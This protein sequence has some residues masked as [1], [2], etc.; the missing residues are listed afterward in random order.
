M[1]HFL[2]RLNEKISLYLGEWTEAPLLYDITWR[3]FL[4]TASLLVLL[5]A[6]ERTLRALMNRRLRKEEQRDVPR[7]WLQVF[8]SSTGK[9]LSLIIWVYGIYIVFRPVLVRFELEDGTNPIY[10]AVRLMA[11]VGGTIALFWFGMRFLKLVDHFYLRWAS[12]QSGVLKSLAASLSQSSPAPL[13][14]LMFLLLFRI[15][16]SFFHLPDLP[17]SFHAF[18]TNV[19]GVVLIASISWLL[20]EGARV[21]ELFLLSF[22]RVDVA[23]NRQARR[24]HTQLRFLRHFIVILVFI[25][26]LASILMLFDQV[27]QLGASLLASAGVLGIVVGLAA[28]RSIANLLVGLQIA[29]TQPITLDDV[30]I[31]EGEWG[32]IEEITAT[33]V[34]VRIWDRRCLIVPL[35]YFTETPFQNWTRTS[36]QILGTIFLYVDYT[37]N[38]E[39]IR[40]KLKELV[41]ESTHWDGRVCGLVVTDSRERT[42]ELRCLVSAADSSSAWDLRCEIREKLIAHIQEHYPGS[43]PRVRMEVEL[44]EGKGRE[45]MHRAPLPEARPFPEEEP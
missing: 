40:Q 7:P 4:F 41:Q 38:V 29:L 36:A 32:R 43:L 5:L 31:I 14:L 27:R 35:T 26:G 23:D 10:A 8:L 6:A 16:L 25:L 39:K 28:Q 22:Y 1:D 17:E 30:V 20:V 24:I 42:M 34:V 44:P 15:V 9:P 18:L 33:Y 11:D 19:F 3:E 13:K 37:V 45:G 21:M 12:S 2:E